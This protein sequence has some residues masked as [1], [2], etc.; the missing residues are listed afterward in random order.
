MSAQPNSHLA[1]QAKRLA[2]AMLAGEFVE[3]ALTARITPLVKG[4]L[5]W[6]DRQ[7]SRV[8]ARFGTCRPR[9]K[10]LVRFLCQDR[11]FLKA[12][13]KE[14]FDIVPGFDSTVFVP[15]TGL[16]QATTV[17]PWDTVSDFSDWLGLRVNELNWFADQKRLLQKTPDG[18][19]RHYRYHWIRKRR[20][21]CRLVEVPKPRLREIQRRLLRNVFEQMP[22]HEAAHGFRRGRSVATHVSPHTE[23][24]LV[25]K[26]DLQDF[27][28]SI[29]PGRLLR[30]L[31]QAGYAE[32][33]AQVITSLCVNSV[34][35]DA[36]TDWP[37]PDS[38][39]Q[40]RASERLYQKP[41]FPQGSPASPAIANLC[42]YRLDCRLTGLANWADATYTRYADDLLF[43]GGESFRRKADRFPVFV[44]AIAMEEGFLVNHHKTKVM[45]KSV[46]QEAVG[47]VLN[48][49]AQTA[50]TDYDRLRAI[51]HNCVHLGVESQNRES[52]ADFREHLL[53]RINYVSQWSNS[54]RNKLMFLYNRIV[55]P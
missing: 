44:A 1:Y 21:C 34:P 52:R 28:P 26:M 5:R 48:Q 24:E 23:K 33:V 39:S 16:Q 29:A 7:V 17:L 47:L 25:L 51:L 31:M 22:V 14:D 18:P 45:S 27:F 12:A 41:H 20:G 10:D 8:V 55:W 3:A 2:A 35:A 15:A 19:L 11:F 13:A 50:R 36:W 42:A 30:L 54:R 6:L 40:K 43:S 4:N 9:Q 49:K 46:R 38:R 37:Y 53:G 32:P